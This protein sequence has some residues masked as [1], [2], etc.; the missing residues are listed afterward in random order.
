MATVVTKA[1]EEPKKTVKRDTLRAIEQKIQQLWENEHVFEVNAPTIEEEPN[2]SVLHEKYPK[3]MGT[4]PYPYMNGRLHLGHLFTI[5][6]LE[7]A[8]GYERMKGKRALFPLGFHCTGMPIK[9]CADKLSREIE[10]FGPDFKMP[11]Q[12]VLEEGVKDL[13]LNDDNAIKSQDLSDTVTKVTSKKGKVA[14]KS[15]D[16]KYQFKIMQSMG[17]DCKSIG[18]KIDWRR[19]FITTD[20]NPYYDSFVQWQMRKLKDLNK[21]KFGERYTIYSPFDGQPCMDHDRQNGEGVGPQEYTGIKL[22]VVEWSK[23]AQSIL[24]SVKELE[25]KN[26]YFVAATLRPETM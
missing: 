25:D 14:A 2:D 5:T 16:L 6:K 13:G 15:T 23:D 22:Q 1:V 26:I 10:R 17:N 8:T 7:F 12:N 4:F 20:V 24:G 11:D 3:H 21:V 18:A 19:S 9:A